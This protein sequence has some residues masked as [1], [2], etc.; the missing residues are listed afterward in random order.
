MASA[1]A[2]RTRP[3]PIA[4]ATAD[5]TPPPMP[6]FDIIVINMNTGKTSDTPASAA[7]PRKLT[8]YVSATPTNV[9]SVSTTR[10]GAARRSSVGAIRPASSDDGMMTS[11][12][13]VT[14]VIV[15]TC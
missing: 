1:C 5:D 15:V 14:I 3:A 9:C 8:K 4:R 13:V 7:V 10:T 11:F 12:A 6:P 2:S